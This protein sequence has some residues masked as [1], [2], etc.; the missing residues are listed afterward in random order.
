MAEI[1]PAGSSF[2]QLAP[3]WEENAPSE[4]SGAISEPASEPSTSGTDPELQKVPANGYIYHKVG[5]AF[6]CSSSLGVRCCPRPS[7]VR[8]TLPAALQISKL[9]TLAGLAIKYHVTVS[10]RGDSSPGCCLCVLGGPRARLLQLTGLPRC[11]G[12]CSRA[13]IVLQCWQR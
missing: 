5:L 10:R 4:R 13:S 6:C 11:Q 9:D 3:L 8:P 2:P 12:S 7:E 1:A